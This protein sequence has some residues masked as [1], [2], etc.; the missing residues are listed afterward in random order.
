VLRSAVDTSIRH[1]RALLVLL[2]GDVG[3]GKSR[4]ADEVA[5]AATAEHGAVV[6]EGR[7]VPYGEANVWWPVADALRPALGCA[8]A[9]TRVPGARGGGGAGRDAIRRCVGRRPRGR[10]TAEGLLTLLG[11]EPPGEAR[12]RHRGAQEAGRA[13]GAY[14]ARPRLRRRP[15]LLQISDLHWAD[16]RRARAARRRLRRHP[17]PSGGGA[18]HGPPI[19]ARPVDA[20]AGASQRLVLH[21]DPLDRRPPA[22][23]SGTWWGRP[24][25]TRWPTRSSSAAAAT[26]S[27]SRSW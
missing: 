24:C 8:R 18:G 2:V 25:P 1:Q 14:A 15:L 7:C 16:R 12:P 5:T 13:L 22:S 10:R 4:L 26:R 11:Y 19:A 9:T 6:R 23:C 3:M 20:R 17:P 27:S 21:L